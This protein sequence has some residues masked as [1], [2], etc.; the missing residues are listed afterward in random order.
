ML[1]VQQVNGY[2]CHS[3]N[4][5]RSSI[6]NCNVI[7]QLSVV[8]GQL[9]TSV[10]RLESQALGKLPSQTVNNPKQ[11]KEIVKESST[12]QTDQPQET[13]SPQDEI[14]IP[15]SFPS[16]FTKSRR[17]EQEKEIL[18]TFR[19]VK[20]I[21]PLLD[22]IKQVPRYEKFLKELCTSKRKLK[23][24]EKVML[25]ENVSAMIQKK[26]PIKCK[27]PCM[28]TIPCKMGN[29]EIERPML[30]LGASINI[31]PRPIYEAMNV[32]KLKKTRVI[33][34]L[35]GRSYAYPDGV[36]EDILDQVKDLVFPVDFY[37]VDIG[38]DNHY[39]TPSILLGRPFF[40]IARTNICVH[41][42][43]LTM[44]LDGQV[45]KFNIYDSMN[46]PI[47]EHSV[48]SIDVIDSL[49]QK[50]F[51]LNDED[52]LKVA[53]TNTIS[54]NANQELEPNL[55]LQESI[56][57][58]NSLAPVNKI[59]SYLGLPL[60]NAKILSLIVQ[61]PKLE[62]KK[63]LD[64]LKYLFLR[65][66]DTLPVISFNKL[67]S[68]KDKR[69]IRVLRDYKKAIGWTVDDINGMSPSM[70]THKILLEKG[71]NPVK[72][73]QCR[74]NP[75]M[76]EVVKKEIQKLLDA[77][78]IYPISNSKWV[79][80][81]QVVPKKTGVTVVEN[82]DDQMLERL[83]GRAYYCCLDG[84]SCFHQIPV[85]PEDQENTTFSCSFGTFA[86]RRMPFGLCYAPATFQRCMVSLFSEYV[87]DIIEVFMDDFTV[88][89]DSFDSCLLNLEK[90][91]K[92]CIESNLVLNYEKC[93]FMVDQCNILGHIVSAKGLKVDKA[94]T[95]VIKSLPYPK[96][97]REVC[98]FLGH[99][100]FYRR[101][102]K[103]FS[104]TNQPL[105]KLLQK[106]VAFEFDDD[107]KVSFD[108]LKEL[109]TS[110]PIIQPP[111]WNLPLEI[112]SDASN[113]AI[114]VVL[115][116]RVGKSAHVIYYASRTL[117]SAQCN[118]TTTEKELLLYT[119]LKKEAKPRLIRWILILQEFNLEIRDKK[120]FENL[121]ADHLNRVMVKEESLSWKDEFPDE[122]LFVVQTTNPW[123]GTTQA[124]ISDRGTHFCNR[125]M[126]ALLKKY[127]VTHRVS[128]AYH[129]QTNGQAEVSNR[130][131]K[132]ILK[133]T[134]NPNRKDWSIKLDH[135]LWAYHTTYKTP[136][137][138][139][140]F[141]LVFGKACHLPVELEHKAYWAVKNLN[142]KLD[143][144]GANRK[145]QLQELEEIC[146]D[147]YDSSRIY[148]KKLNL[149]MIK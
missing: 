132:S 28:F 10:N 62:L 130:E 33:I 124:I 79:S 56:A 117:D 35:A 13:T 41:E 83:A 143:D 148:K 133:K 17:Q 84:Y 18:E 142:M 20:I 121:V 85:A 14:K 99:A 73:V 101:F 22:A 87:E 2:T 110:S 45:I 100:G 29:V 114:G 32:G 93:Q 66:R 122:H 91:L 90:I 9:A 38:K 70:C 126:K 144:V 4:C 75:P 72:Q 141:R 68:L 55:N 107:C 94:K 31:M 30:D 109:L 61:A 5:A 60:N 113:Y 112:M 46:Y 82:S 135:A 95:Y 6:R 71:A 27:D 23:G 81:I 25:G 120:G 59:V 136:I 134:V 24:N 96:N 42:G 19:K 105:C 44:E 67:T 7:P 16:R 111:D 108:K 37:V 146:N 48:F 128:T 97:V 145:L 86:F 123:F 1:T 39:N 92:R 129:P 115:G 125:V 49:V 3:S 116:Q 119:Y 77:D 140:P 64:H 15:P 102:I 57:K 127:N 89:G 58:I 88:H 8:S 149:F 76:M 78:I 51:A 36:L 65:E 138:M 40:K 131:I 53:L 118:Y 54:E 43:T 147:T 21:I 63:L 47:N 103:D 106:D 52:S 98:S 50:D 69:L 137:G 104:K 26:F 34:Q 139:S 11:N 12:S 80:P 74:L